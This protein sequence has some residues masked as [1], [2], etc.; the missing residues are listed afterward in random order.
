MRLIYPLFCSY[1]YLVLLATAAAG[2]RPNV[3]VLLADD[4]GSKDIGC[5]GG[6]VKTPALD[7]LAAKGVRFTD[8]HSGAPVCSPARATLLTGRHHL[9]TGVYTVIQDHIH[10]M[11]LRKSEVTIA[12]L[13]KANGYDTVHLGKWHLGTPFRGM[14]KP[15]ID[16]HGFDYWFATDLNA[17]PSHRNP[18]NFWR[19]RERVGELK[20]YDCQLVVDEAITW[21]GEKRDAEKP[22]FL[23]I[24]FH[25]PHAPLAAPDEIISQYGELNDPAAI[26]SGTIDN[27][28]RAIARLLKKL[29]QIDSL[30][31]TIIIYTSDH[32]S[33]RHERNGELRGGKGSLLEGGTRTP[34]IIHWPRGIKGGR[35]EDTP[36][37][38]I[39]L[40]PT[41]CGLIGIEKPESVHLDG[42]DLS[43]LLTGHPS[44]FKR[45]QPLTWHSPTSQPIVVIR[46]G[47]YSLVGYRKIEYP[48]DQE[49]IRS[50]MDEMNVILEKQHG[51]KLTR[52]ELWH[53]AYN[54]E[55]KTPE[56]NRLRGKFVTL[57]T[58][59]EAWIPLIKEGSGGISKFELYNLSIDPNQKQNIAER[60]PEVTN[61]LKEQV[62]AINADVLKEAPEWGPYKPIVSS[63]TRPNPKPAADDAKLE[64]LLTKI[65][66]AV[67]PAGYD[68]SKH[69]AYVDGRMKSLQSQQRGRIGLLWKEKRRLHPNMQNAGVS[70]VRIL[71]YVAAGE[72]LAAEDGIDTQGVNW[73]QWR[74]PEANGVSRAAKPPVEWSEDK[75]VRWK[76]AINGKG[77]ASPIIWGDKVFLLTAINTGRVDPSRA[78]PEDQPKRVFGIKHPNTFYKFEVLC[79]D[80]NTGEELWRQTASEH[81]PH[82]GTHHDADFASAS[83][84]TD[85][86]RLYCWFGSAGMYCYDLDGRKLWERDLGKAYVGASLGEGCSPVVHQGKLVIV[87]DHARQSS[88]DVLD[89]RTGKTLWKKDRDEPN[90]WATPR[91]VEHSGKTQVITAASNMIRSYDLDNGDI[92]WQCSGLTGNVTPCPIVDGDVVYCMSGYE[93]YSLLALPLNARG[94][95]SNSDKTVWSRNNGTPYVPSP[96]LY[97]GILYFTQSN[98]AI[99]TAVDSRTGKTLLKRSRIP[100]V[101]N[102]YSSPVGADGRVYFTGRNGATVVLKR[103]NKLEVLMTNKLDDEFNASPAIAGRQL[104]LR[105]RKSLYCLENR[106]NGGDSGKKASIEEK[107]RIHR[108]ATTK[109]STFDAFSYVNRIP[110][111]PYDDETAEDFA[112]R[113]FGRL[114]N[115]EGRVLLKAPVGMHRLAYDGFKTFLGYEGTANVGNCAACHTPADFTDGKSH[116][117]SKGGIAKP[118]PSLRN[119]AK[120]RVDLRK[121]LLQKLEASRQKRSGGADGI[122]DVYSAMKLS[123]GD[124]PGLV[125]FLKLLED[126]PDDR[127]RKLILEAT[128]LDTSE[129]SDE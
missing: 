27:T 30:E 62:L 126:V 116:V 53:K 125:A 52:A 18:N 117:V 84:T 79:L 66:K 35:V 60:L 1:L 28:D 111:K 17:A 77:N 45:H 40:L 129:E 41:I 107:T 46:E 86:E 98:Q 67:L 2:Q 65:D 50:V 97:D 118:T 3:V 59:Q 63:T 68:P 87:R 128:V 13:L 22:F 21:L 6:P 32:G 94:D 7:G 91:I 122:S 29:E 25:E 39:D 81:V 78:K 90:A 74:G 57:N 19:N 5:D 75:N 43:S 70:F 80:R 114:A 64:N 42:T 72:K 115:Q 15:W 33:Y 105:G 93:G 109:R 103:S 38:A 127:F 36:A 71:E 11:N 20:G 54:S 110:E 92:I 37:G 73:H 119:L 23:N 82:E 76:V 24:W 47:K 16:E 120:R 123:E 85:G 58:F 69:Q 104:F 4:L 113:I 49:T 96:V 83:P 26:Y 9:R 124:I 12:E 48:K 95:I 88:I 14:K 112:G 89:A 121:T 100:G 51:R 55:I 101:S 10:N 102:I 44:D 108:L 106:I 56:W 8:F 61:R 99:L 34:G 31:N